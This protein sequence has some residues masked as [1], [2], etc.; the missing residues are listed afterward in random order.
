MYKRLLFVCLALVVLRFPDKLYAQFTDP[1]DYDNVPVGVNQLE[2]AYAYARSNASIDTSLIIAGAKVNLNQGTPDYRRYFSLIHRLAWVEA[3]VPLAGLGGSV[4]GTNIHGSVTGVGDSSYT[5]A[6]LL[7]GGPAL[8]VA[9]FA[10]Y[11]PATT[12]GVSLSITAPTGL[13]NAN[14]FLNLGSHR[15]SFKPEIA[16]SHPF[17]PEQE[18]EFDV[19]ANV[20]FYTD[21]T[22]YL[23]KKILRQQALPGFEAHISYSF[24]RTLWASVDTR[25]SLHGN[26]FVDGVHQNDGQQNFTLGSEVNISLNDQNSFVF[27]IAKALVHQNGPAYTGFA[28]KYSYNWGKGY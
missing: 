7:K 21:N 10:S 16:V 25:Y 28:V 8:S 1:R 15:W 9:Q 22:S 14:K 26:T 2:I 5:L 3:S 27:E 19:Y 17:G 12:L 23:G 11:K 18:W 4:T 13:Y 20:D 6:V 24:T